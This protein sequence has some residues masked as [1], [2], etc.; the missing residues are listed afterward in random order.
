[1]TDVHAQPPRAGLEQQLGPVRR[2]LLE[3]ARAAAAQVLGAARAE[4]QQIVAGAQQESDEAV[5]RAR[6]RAA[7]AAR[8]L[9]EQAQAAA[10][11][12]A[13]GTVLRAEADLHLQLAAEVYA[14][15]ERLAQD[16][17]YPLLLD[18]LEGLARS[19]L[20]EEAVVTRDPQPGG[21]VV[22]TAG[23][24]R[25]DYRLR[26]LADLAMAAVADEMTPTGDGE[27][28]PWH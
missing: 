22:A 13:H 28:E 21:G 15:A 4:A 16:P 3:D 8:A 6:Q 23:G 5:E 9:S 27:G 18:H 2:A 24:R 20:G 26:A 10:R 19:Q 7:A 25:V 14:A 12:D 11:R 17:R 1:V